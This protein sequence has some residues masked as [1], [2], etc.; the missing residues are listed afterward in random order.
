MAKQK[1]NIGDL[2][3][4]SAYGLGVVLEVDSIKSNDGLNRQ[5]TRKR[6][7]Y[8]IIRFAKLSHKY[9]LWRDS[10]LWNQLTVISRGQ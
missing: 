3:E 5:K 7:H 9:Q 8:A 1:L 2:V 6:R 10:K 4:W